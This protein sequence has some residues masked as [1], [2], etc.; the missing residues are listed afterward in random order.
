MKPEDDKASMVARRFWFGAG[1]GVLFVAG[2]WIFAFTTYKVPRTT[3]GVE[4]LLHGPL[5]L[6]GVIGIVFGV[7]LEYLL[8]RRRKPK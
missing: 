4:G 2:L 5:P 1:G 7:A 8:E 3:S 6:A